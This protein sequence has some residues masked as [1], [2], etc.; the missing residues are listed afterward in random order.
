MDIV[1]AMGLILAVVGGVSVAACAPPTPKVQQPGVAS[2]VIEKEPLV[3]I[4]DPNGSFR[5]TVRRE[6]VAALTRYG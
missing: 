3:P 5:Y 6:S 2:Q 4:R 1:R